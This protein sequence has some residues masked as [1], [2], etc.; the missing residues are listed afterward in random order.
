MV[1]GSDPGMRAPTVYPLDGLCTTRSSIP[2]TAAYGQLGV[3]PKRISL[4]IHHQFSS[5]FVAAIHET[6]RGERLYKI[7]AHA[8]LYI[9]G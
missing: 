3:E 1:A 5:L 7:R 2:R 6:Q 9:T 8:L 4:R